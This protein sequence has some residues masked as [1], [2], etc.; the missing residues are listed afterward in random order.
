MVTQEEAQINFD[1]AKSRLFNKQSEIRRLRKQS[2]FP[3]VRISD[4]FDVGI[5][6]IKPFRKRR[7]MERRETFKQIGLSESALPMLRDE[8]NLKKSELDVF[9]TPGLGDLL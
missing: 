8:F 2:F 1:F 7:K 6:G 3:G 5:S 4:Q 9:N